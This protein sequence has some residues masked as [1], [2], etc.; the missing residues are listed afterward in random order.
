MTDFFSLPS[1]MGKSR[2]ATCIIA[3][4]L[5]KDAGTTPAQ[6]LSRLQAARPICEPNEGFMKQLELYHQM[7]C[8]ENVDL[9][10]AY[11]RWL[12]KREVESSV[13]CGLAPENIKFRNEEE[14][15]HEDDGAEGLELRCRKCR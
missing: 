1:A 6:A 5:H 8:P 4:L 12:Y 15:S 13:A 10:P 7:H 3:Y 2:S 9:E 14:T 11:Q